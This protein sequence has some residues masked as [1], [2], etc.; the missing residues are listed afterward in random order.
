MA[1]SGIYNFFG[2]NNVANSLLEI[3]SNPWKN[4]TYLEFSKP[5]LRNPHYCLE[6]LKPPLLSGVFKILTNAY[7]LKIL[8]L[9][10]CSFRIF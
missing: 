9:P 8:V 5:S 4:T 2:R 3:F 10:V 7:D 6:F 1:L